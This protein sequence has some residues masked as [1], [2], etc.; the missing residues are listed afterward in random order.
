MLSEIERIVEARKT[1][2]H[3]KF[4]FD[5]SLDRLEE[6]INAACEHFE[7]ESGKM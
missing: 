2:V 4:P 1:L 5:R 6:T 7:V 3:T